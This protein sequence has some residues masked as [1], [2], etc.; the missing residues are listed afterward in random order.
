MVKRAITDR[1]INY[2]DNFDRIEDK[3]Y[4]SHAP[5]INKS[6]DDFSADSQYT[7]Y[8]HDDDVNTEVET[9]INKK[10]FK[11]HD[12]F[13]S[14]DY[15]NDSFRHKDWMDDLDEGI[16]KDLDFDSFIGDE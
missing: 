4:G 1:K 2:G 5:V 15:K 6:G 11:I 7:L 10:R 8:I 13:C 3:V 9:G 16:L 14:N 12:G